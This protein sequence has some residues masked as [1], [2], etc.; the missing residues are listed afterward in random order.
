MIR[1]GLTV[2]ALGTLW[3]LLALLTLRTL[4]SLGAL[5]RG[6]RDFRYGDRGLLRGIVIGDTDLGWAGTDAQKAGL[7]PL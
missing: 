7:G 5:R 3:T 4:C 6:G 2:L 1:T